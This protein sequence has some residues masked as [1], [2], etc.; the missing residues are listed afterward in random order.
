MPKS[1]S[2]IRQKETEPNSNQVILFIDDELKILKDLKKPISKVRSL[3]TN[4]VFPQN[5][6]KISGDE[7]QRISLVL[8]DQF[9]DN[10][11]F[12]EITREFLE[13][14]TLINP[15]VEVIE[16][17][18]YLQSSVY[19][20]S[21]GSLDTLELNDEIK[22]DMVNWPKTADGFIN[23]LKWKAIYAFRE[24]DKVD[25]TN[26]NE[27][28]FMKSFIFLLNSFDQLTKDSNYSKLLTLLSVSEDQFTFTFMSDNNI[29]RRKKFLHH[30]WQTIRHIVFNN[31][32]EFYGMSVQ[33]LKEILLLDDQNI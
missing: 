12:E 7:M 22:E 17:S 10:N 19:K 3:D 25:K 13:K 4:F 26:D 9:L 23:K 20:N 6:A 1:E 14:L 18:Y 2:E 28:D 33:R 24:A 29:N 32:E 16:I 15:K 30:S 27:S 31:S 21:I 8:A 11:Y 5:L